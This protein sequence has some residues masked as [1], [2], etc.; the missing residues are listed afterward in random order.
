M[1][2]VWKHGKIPKN[3]SR[4][5]ST[6]HLCKR[7]SDRKLIIIKEI[8]VEQM[9]KD[10]RQSA[11]NE[12]KVL[13]MLDH[14]NIIEYYENFLED[15]ALMIV[16]EYAQGGTLYDYLQQKGDN[17]LEEEQILHYFAQMLLSLQHVHS[18]QILH[19]DLKTQNILLDKKKEVVKI[20]DFG[21]SKVLS[22]KSK[23][24]SV[25]GTPC[26]ISPEL[27]EGK[28]YNQ[29]S[30]IWALGCVL[31]E[32]ASLKRAFEAQN[33]PALILKIMRG[34]FSP[35]SDKYSK[36]LQS[37]ILS[38]L[39]L[40]PNKRPHINQIMAQPI[41]INSLMNL[42]TD[43]GMLPC[44]R[45]QS[46]LSSLPGQARGATGGGGGGKLSPRPGSATRE[47]LASLVMDSSGGLPKPPV[48]CSVYYWGSGISSPM[49]LPL[50]SS[51]TQVEEVSIGRTQK[52]AVTK[53]GR[54][55]VWEAPTVGTDSMLP[56]AT[57]GQVPAF[58]PRYLEGQSAVTIQHVACGDLF[59]ACLTDRGILMTFG[60]GANGCL[61]HGNFNDVSQAKIVEALLGYEVVQVSCGACHVLAVTN[62]HEV[63]AWG[64]GDNGRLGLGTQESHSLPQQVGF[65]ET[66]QP[67]SVQ[68]GVDCSM[69]LTVENKLL[70]C[71]NN[72]YNKLALD[73][74]GS[75]GSLRHIEEVH[76][77]TPVSTPPL[78]NTPIKQVAMG[79]SHTIVI[80][81]QGE[82][83]SFGSN[84]FG[85]LGYNK[86]PT[87][88]YPEKIP[89][90]QGVPVTMVAGGDTF[91]V[92]VAG[93]IVYSWGKAARGR[94]G[95]SGDITDIP[96]PITFTDQDRFNV[97][98]VSCC[99]GNT[100]L[101][102][103][104]VQQPGTPRE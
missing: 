45:V 22:S 68:C 38:M 33:L 49:L 84:Q 56:G 16:M 30:D 41:L 75:G 102:T 3:T 48:L 2:F 26:Y 50:P 24:Y 76:T 103:C 20:G 93:G 100:L 42:Y 54:L 11:L 80:T 58:V 14:P 69:L 98:S 53:N 6:V 47:S 91:S 1:S 66:E 5:K 64:R 35:I 88:G 43:I 89:A 17:L 46:P 94:L 34:T 73:T 15:K 70:C 95:R 101:A 59:T 78:V 12:V 19:R 63:F 87:D 85:Q 79:T 77:F 82:C 39:H 71:G 57:E 21:I 29:K 97:T 44:T 28:P 99:H 104:P 9:T 18:K 7:I 25:V 37:L 90:L 96:Q 10:E 83:Y 81:E 32:L 60:S 61:G 40:D 55:F 36:E 8:P 67:C 4:R 92:A 72:R 62:D 74:A 27:C 23:A 52:A 13:S 51:D 31:Y 86:R 65:E